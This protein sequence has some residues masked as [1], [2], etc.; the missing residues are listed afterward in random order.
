MSTLQTKTI[1]AIEKAATDAGMEA[2]FEHICSND[3]KIHFQA[4]DAFETLL[5]VGFHFQNG[6]NY[7]QSETPLWPARAGSKD[8]SNA[9]RFIVGAHN[10]SDMGYVVSQIAAHLQ[11]CAAAH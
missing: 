9:K 5:T 6:H 11:G 7:F 8:G 4:P 3:G 2:V 10:P 1:T